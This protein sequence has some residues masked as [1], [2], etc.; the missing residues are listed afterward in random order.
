VSEKQIVPL[1][2]Y[3]SDTT[4]EGVL[5]SDVLL[6]VPLLIVEC[7]IWSE[8]DV[9]GDKTRER[10]HIHLTHLNENAER[11]QNRHVALTHVSPRYARSQ[12]QRLL[13]D[14]RFAQ[15]LEARGAT[16]HLLM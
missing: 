1:L 3:T 5:Q 10:G 11:F 15:V 7:T 13:A 6:S 4:I 12:C 14:S 2:A 9:S 16:V 8:D